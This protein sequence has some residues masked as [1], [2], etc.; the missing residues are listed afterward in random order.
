[1][2]EPEWLTVKQVAAHAQVSEETVRRWLR[3]GE[4]HGHK[5]GRRAGYRVRRDDLERFM[6]GEGDA[7]AGRLRDQE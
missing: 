3:G 1:M 7:D 4:L 5:I 6:K 2:T